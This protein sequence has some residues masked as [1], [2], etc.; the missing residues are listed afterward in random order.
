M[1]T[2][3]EKIDAA[4]LKLARNINQ[5]KARVAG[6]CWMDSDFCD[7]TYCLC[8]QESLRIAQDKQRENKNG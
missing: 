1:W 7:D 4:I 3:V 2:K 8:A 6:G 5:A